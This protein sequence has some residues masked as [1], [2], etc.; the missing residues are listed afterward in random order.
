MLIYRFKPK[1]RADLRVALTSD[2]TG[3]ILPKDGAPWQAIGQVDLSAN[4]P[5]INVPVAD[6]EATI[7]SNG[8]F[9]WSISIPTFKP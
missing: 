5:W 1:A 9:I 4:A 6:I 8:Y 3:Q 2:E 7:E